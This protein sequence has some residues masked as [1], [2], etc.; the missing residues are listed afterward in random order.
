MCVNTFWSF[1]SLSLSFTA[2]P[3]VRVWFL[4]FLFFIVQSLFKSIPVNLA[5]LV[6]VSMEYIHPWW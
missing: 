3:A 1:P 4:F 5:F 6:L 2:P